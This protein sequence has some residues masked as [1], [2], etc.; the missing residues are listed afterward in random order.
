MGITA[1][2]IGSGLD[3]EGI[4]QQLV[5]AE[6][7]PVDQ[8]LDSK[9]E[10]IQARITAFGSL[11]SGLSSF[12]SALADLTTAAGFQKTSVTSSNSSVFTATASGSVTP[13]DF[14]IEITSLAQ[15]HKLASKAF[16][17]TTDA[18]GTGVLTFRF[19]TYD[20]G[21]NTFT[22][23][24]D[25][26]I[27][28]VTIDGTNNSLQGIRDAVNA[29]D[30]GVSASIVNDGSGYRLLFKSDDSGAAN[31]LEVTVSDTGDSNDLDDAGL[32]QLAYDPT[33]AGVGSGKNL[34]QTS[35]AKDAAF[36][37]DGLAMT[38]STNTVTGAIE[39][40]TL[41]LKAQT[42][43][44]PETL[45]VGQDK[46]A[47]SSMIGSFVSGYNT[48]KGVLE[49][50]AGYDAATQTG[51]VLMGDS[52]INGVGNQINTI[53]SGA[54]SGLT[55][56]YTALS[57]VGITTQADGTLELDDSVLSAAL[58]DN[59]DAVA[60]VFAATGEPTDALINFTGASSAT[61]AGDYAVTVTQLA[62]QGSYT[63]AA[64]SG[65]PLT[66]DA[67]NDTFEIKVDG[68]QSGTITLTQKSYAS[69]TEL[70]AELQSRINADSALKN[71]SVDV[72]VSFNTDHFEIT[73]SRYGS[74]SKVEFTAVEGSGLG[75]SVGA[76]TDGVDVAGTIGGV[77]ATGSGRELRGTGDADG[78]QLDVLGGALGDRGTVSFT[79]GVA[80]QLDSSLDAYLGTDN[81]IDM[82][83]DG[84]DTTLD[85]ISDQRDRLDER[86]LSL[87]A[88]YRAQFTALDLLVSQLQ[89]TSSFL[90]QQLSNLPGAYK[91]KSS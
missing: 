40:V 23:N 14:S 64:T 36:S 50:L 63:G 41:E 32:S 66:V 44:T 82:R 21:A 70:A 57:Q 81:L 80:D 55:G 37:I 87:E 17:N 59:F 60:R 47:V 75:L 29:A 22:A 61:K 19:G 46:A 72:V 51:G 65:F 85:S 12:Q 13:G 5:L 67:S 7:T 91:V 58:N 84:L 30:I 25:K 74:A 18:V 4:V 45:S 6:R 49:S 42:S 8:R 48:L 3:I 2:G 35:E 34:S 38:R 39:G 88:R 68:V 73:S 90:T 10:D 89:S 20:S 16:A 1:T 28:T 54:V 77:A 9:E 24:P 76:G 69:G 11:K 79:R 33:A 27:E 26:T 62:T 15:S 31:S 43:G 83:T 52:L 86:M 56:K 71:A 78:L 53:L